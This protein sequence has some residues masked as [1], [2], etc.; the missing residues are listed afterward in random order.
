MNCWLV[1]GAMAG[2]AGVTAMD[3]SVAGFMVRPV[4]PDTLPDAAVIVVEPDA[5]AVASPLEPAVLLIVAAPVE[6]LQVTVLVISCVVLS[7][8]VPVAMN[9][10]FVPLATFGL[11]GVIARD[12]SVA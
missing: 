7:E 4:A 1:P 8:K 5:T 10:S 11:V 9:C 6:E 3:R 12:A 2:F